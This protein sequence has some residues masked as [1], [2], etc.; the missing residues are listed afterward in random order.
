MMVPVIPMMTTSRGARTVVARRMAESVSEPSS[1]VCVARAIAGPGPGIDGCAGAVLQRGLVAAVVPDVRRA[2]PVPVCAGV[3]S[4]AGVQ[5]QTF[6]S[7]QGEGA[8][9]VDVTLGIPNRPAGQGPVAGADVFDRDVLGVK[10]GV[11][12]VVRAGR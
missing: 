10:A 8:E 7:L 3:G 12:S 9:R 11:G 4:L 2:A 6:A 1:A 5:S